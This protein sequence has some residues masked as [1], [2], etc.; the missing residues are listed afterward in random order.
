MGEKREV[1]FE[2]TPAG[3]VVKVTAI[4]PITGVEATIQGPASAGP[5]L[6]KRNAVQK[7]KFLIAKEK[8]K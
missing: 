2:I 1:L 4:D 7:L 3:H 5:E 8:K 6:L